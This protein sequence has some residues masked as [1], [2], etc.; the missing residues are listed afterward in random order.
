MKLILPKELAAV[1]MDSTLQ[2]KAIA[3]STDSKLLETATGSS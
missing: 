3:H 1:V 2:Y